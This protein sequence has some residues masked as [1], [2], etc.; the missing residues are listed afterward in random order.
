VLRDP[1][2]LRE[3]LTS[4]VLA[5]MEGAMQ[6]PPWVLGHS[7][8]GP[9]RKGRMFQRRDGRMAEPG[10]PAL[11]GL[12][13]DRHCRRA[14]RAATSQ[15]RRCTRCWPRWCL[16][17]RPPTCS[18]A[19]PPAPA[20]AATAAAAAVPLWRAAL[21]PRRRRGRRAAR[22]ARGRHAGTGA[23]PI[24][25]LALQ[26]DDGLEKGT[27]AMP[28]SRRQTTPTHPPCQVLHAPDVLVAALRP[29]GAGSLCRVQGPRRG[30]WV[31]AYWSH[32][33]RS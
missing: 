1:A 3:M 13:P 9:A 33:E 17:Q 26:D 14:R 32:A 2:G 22:G 16:R 20:A 10:L 27:C 24:T 28:K 19:R 25:R 15:Q 7:T 5:A 6:V 4:E 18:G 23:G 21:R 30:A 31:A 8:K 11:T 29:Q 12:H